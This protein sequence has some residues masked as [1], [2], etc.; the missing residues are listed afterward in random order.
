MYGLLIALAG[1]FFASRIFVGKGMHPKASMWS[2][3]FLTM[4]IVLAPA[5]L[6][7]Q[8]SDGASAAFYSRLLLFFIIAIYGSVSLA[9]FD[10]FWPFKDSASSES[11]EKPER[12]SEWLPSVGV[13]LSE[14]APGSWSWLL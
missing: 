10:A 3:A 5:L 13:G 7:G 6:D 9:I 14:L 1:L 4:I 11:N 8:T 12:K 2:Y